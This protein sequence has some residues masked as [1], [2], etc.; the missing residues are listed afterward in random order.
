MKYG[1]SPSLNL[2]YNATYYVSY[3]KIGSWPDD[4]ISVN[5][6]TFLEYSDKAP[7]GKVRGKDKSG[8][9]CWVDLPLPTREEQIDA[10]KAEIK[11]RFDEANSYI[12][13]HQWPSKF[14][15]GRLGVLE[16]SMFNKAG[17][18]GRVNEHRCYNCP[19]CSVANNIVREIK[20]KEVHVIQIVNL[21]VI[22]SFFQR[23]HLADCYERSFN[24][25]I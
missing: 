4:V 18:F 14:A 20:Y 13:Y 1:N 3:I 17:L 15:L 22:L 6:N 10:A 23:E 7:E 2:F 25:F 12:N 16:T 9:P 11:R 8:F 21:L 24:I 5:E 19:K